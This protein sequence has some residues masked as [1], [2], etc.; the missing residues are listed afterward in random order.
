MVSLAQRRCMVEHL[1]HHY[2]VSQRRACRVAQIARSS[3][4]CVPGR[5]DRLEQIEVVVD[6]SYRYPRFGYRKIQHLSQGAG[7]RI[8]R[9][10]VRLIRKRE[11]LQVLKKQKKKRLLGQSTTHLKQAEFA[12]HVWSYDFVHDQT[13][14]GRRVKY[15]TI[16]DEFTHESLM[17]WLDRTITSTRLISC[18][19][20]LF[21]LYGKPMCIKS[22][23]G[24][25]FIASQLQD[26]LK[27]NHVDVRYIDP[28]SPW[29]N[30]HNES[31]NGVFRDGC[32]NR[33]S[34]YSLAEARRVVEQW[35]DE[36]N[37]IRPHGSIN[38]MTPHEFAAVHRQVT[39]QA[40]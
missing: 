4:R 21:E 38:M 3:H 10:G 14:D 2:A 36:Y 20:Y 28:G 33:W 13:E 26:W 5:A 35:R 34:F 15:L 32:L 8:S 6:L 22:D 11:G 39:H 19:D 16:V 37:T 40:A 7:Q 29:Q 24:P 12:N 30:G 25:E 9:E 1:Q 31:F 17:I 18:L 27:A 23:N